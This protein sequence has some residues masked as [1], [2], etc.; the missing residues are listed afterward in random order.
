MYKAADASNS[1]SRGRS[2]CWPPCGLFLKNASVIGSRLRSK[3][4]PMTSA[5]VN[6]SNDS[7]LCAAFRRWCGWSMGGR[8]RMYRD[9]PAIPL[10]QPTAAAPKVQSD[11]ACFAPETSHRPRPPARPQA[12]APPRSLPN[13]YRVSFPDA[14]GSNTTLPPRQSAG[15]FA[16]LRLRVFRC[17]SRVQLLKPPNAPKANSFATRQ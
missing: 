1:L 12:R 10:N 4:V 17:H 7:P 3:F 14:F 6:A 15:Q 11:Q 2:P 16:M 5:K 8:K 9:R 13:A